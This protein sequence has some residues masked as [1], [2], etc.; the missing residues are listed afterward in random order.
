MTSPKRLAR[1]AG[2]L[3]LTVAILG[4]F[5][6]LYS[7][8]TVFVP[9]DARATADNVVANSAL[10][11]AGFVADLV[12][13]ACFLFVGFALYL[14]LS[15]V[16]KNVARAM[17][18]FVA[19]SVSIMCLNLVHHY[20]ALIVATDGTYQDALGSDGA[21]ALVLLMLDLHQYGYLIAQIFFGL[22]LL[23]LGYLVFKSGMFPRALGVLLAVGC[24]GYLVDL[25]ARFLFPEVGA[26]LGPFATT[27]A[28]VAELAMVFWL[29]V[30]GVRIPVRDERIHVAA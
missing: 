22:W 3:Y 10:F 18:I 30:K 17:V 6:H 14:L 29:L 9:G 26:I 15:H 7:R 1:I 13:A 28:A 23:P 19:I 24:L 16:N 4:G 5:A 8:A 25:F 20:A 21:D 27:P 12:Q 11:R 2:I